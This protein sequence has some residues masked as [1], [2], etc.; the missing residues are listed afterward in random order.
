MISGLRLLS[1][2]RRIPSGARWALAGLAAVGFAVLRA[3]FAGKRKGRAAGA[4]KERMAAA[5]QD[6]ERV[7]DAAARGDD[8]A[9]Q[10]ELAEAVERAKRSRSK[11]R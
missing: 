1:L 11:K 7:M 2:A 8:A 10:R 4:A 6:V 3:F 5:E 9:V